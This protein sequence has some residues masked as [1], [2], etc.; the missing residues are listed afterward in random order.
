MWIPFPILW[1]CFFFLLHWHLLNLL[2]FS[3]ACVCCIVDLYLFYQSAHHYAISQVHPSWITSCGVTTLKFSSIPMS[4]HSFRKLQDS[5]DSVILFY[6]IIW[7]F[8]FC[9]GAYIRRNKFECQKKQFQLDR[10]AP[11]WL[12]G[13]A[14]A[15]GSGHDPRTPQGA[16]FSLHL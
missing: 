5:A 9:I 11:G 15:F 1:L 6:W 2:D 4:K 13:W 16:Y 7:G 3:H 8:L 12:S 10:G 14:S